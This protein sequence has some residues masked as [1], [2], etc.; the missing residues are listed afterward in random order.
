MLK[1]NNRRSAACIIVALVLILITVPCL[2]SLAVSRY[3]VKVT[4]LNLQ[5]DKIQNPFTLVQLTD[6]H[7]ATFGEDNARLIAKIDEIN[8][9]AVLMTGDMIDED[10]DVT[11]A[12]ALVT[13][14]AETYD[15]YFSLGNHEQDCITGNKTD[16]VGIFEKAGAV[17]LEKEYADCEINE[18]KVRIGGTS[19]YALGVKFWEDTYFKDAD[20]YYYSDGFAEQRFMLDFENTDSY[21]ILLLHRPEASTLWNRDG[22][23]DVDIVLS[24]H[25]HG[26]I[27]RFPFIGGLYAPEEGFFPKYEY[28]LYSVDGVITYISSGLS[29]AKGI[30]RFNNI[31]EIVSLTVTPCE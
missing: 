20:N 19:G 6:L 16:P 10:G 22:W 1:G 3:S 17:V 30:P 11:V 21:K 29:G 8:P 24:G 2:I 12:V 9:D 7:G 14:L 27:V 31:P 13:K 15:V 28:G 26:G 4:Y 5:S 18:N 23:F 25:T